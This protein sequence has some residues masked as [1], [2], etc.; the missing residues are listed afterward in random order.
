MTS[1]KISSEYSQVIDLSICIA[2]MHRTKELND[3]LC[4]IL[5][6]SGDLNVQIVVV[7]SSKNRDEAASV[8]LQ[9]SGHIYD[10]T[11][12]PRG[13]D[14]DF[15]RAISLALGKY[16]WLLPDDDQLQP[17]ALKSI[18]REL[19]NDVDY[20]L[21][22]AIVY[23]SNMKLVLQNSMVP[24]DAP[25]T[26]AGP[27]TAKDLV[28]FSRLVSYIG[29]IVILRDNWKSQVAKDFFGTEFAHV[30][31]L[32]TCLPEK[33]MRYVAEPFIKIRY[34]QAHWESRY[35]KIWWTNWEGIMRD[36]ISDTDIQ[37]AWGVF[38][39][40]KKVRD[41][42]YTKALYF[43]RERD[44]RERLEGDQDFSFV[45]VAVFKLIIACPGMLLNRFF[46]LAAKMSKRDNKKMFMYNLNRRLREQNAKA[47]IQ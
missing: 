37:S 25:A 30:G 9:S 2:T 42:A 23:D 47:G 45:Q 21:L 3:L 17:N 4:E 26:L 40:W 19:E 7:D 44:L 16:C 20:L 35:A 41:A 33:G 46:Y 39:G 10:W 38:H 13:I 11:G 14:S 32:L 1:E 29:S 5:K 24:S 36:C 43:A 28:P 31:L 22:N 18:I 12:I 15:D 6:Q 34:G 27:V 8:L